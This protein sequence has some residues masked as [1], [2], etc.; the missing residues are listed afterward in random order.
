MTEIVPKQQQVKQMAISRIKRLLGNMALLM[1]GVVV[2]IAIVE[3]VSR[4]VFPISPG[5]QWVTLDGQPISGLFV[6]GS[7][8][9]QVADEYDALTTIT[10][11][12]YRV[13]TADSDPDVVFLGDSFTYGHGLSDEETFPVIYCRSLGLSCAN[14]G[15]PESG[16]M[17]EINRLEEFLVQYE[18]RPREVKLFIYAMTRSLSPG[19]DLA[20]NLYDSETPQQQTSEP[21]SEPAETDEVL[22]EPTAGEDSPGL[23]ARIVDSRFLVLRY[24]NL[25]RIVKYVLGPQLKTL[26][27]PKLGEQELAKALEFTKLQLD[28]L[29]LISRTYG[30]QYEIYLFHP[31][32]D[33]TGGTAEDT[34]EL[35]S[36]QTEV[37]IHGTAQLFE[38]NPSSYYYKSDLHFNPEGSRLIAEYLVAE[39]K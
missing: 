39:D 3:L 25:A 16:T 18:W 7:T 1:L 20:D 11:E 14:L 38:D 5:L 34:Y 33:I 4:A 36:A 31:V 19:N 21:I 35:I 13:T 12:G 26:L 9:R 27:L 8:Y 28:R 17:D 30:F 23:V 15:A 6:P 22:T 29:E 37:P 24:S 10:E 32:Q 2:A